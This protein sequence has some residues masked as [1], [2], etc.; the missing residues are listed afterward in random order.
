MRLWER[1]LPGSRDALIN[2][3]AQRVAREQYERAWQLLAIRTGSLTS[4]PEARGYIGSRVQNLVQ[5]AIGCL[6]GRRDDLSPELQARIAQR[7]V[8]LWVSQFLVPLLDSA[9]IPALVRVR[10]A[11]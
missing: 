6:A 11:A 3:M 9:P 1:F 5:D 7:T 10:R 2:E 4:V 8:E